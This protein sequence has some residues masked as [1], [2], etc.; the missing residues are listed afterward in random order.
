MRVRVPHSSDEEEGGYGGGDGEPEAATQSQHLSWSGASP[1]G[2]GAWD[3][4]RNGSTGLTTRL[5]AS[6]IGVSGPS[7]LTLGGKE[8]QGKAPGRE[9]GTGKGSKGG[10]A[11]QVVIPLPRPLPKA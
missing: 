11:A 7:T 5:R 6:E 9:K 3:P 1:P 10:E 4:A 2:L 8:P